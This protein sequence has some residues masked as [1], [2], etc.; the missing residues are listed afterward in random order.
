[1]T[2]YDF[3]RLTQAERAEHV[4]HFGKFLASCEER[5]NLYEMGEFYAEV[6][7]NG[8]EN[9]IQEVRAFRTLRNLDPYLSK[10][11]INLDDVM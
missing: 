2:L 4:Y 9:A 1:M 8:E 3:T 10:I 5:G 11:N 6:I 7:Y